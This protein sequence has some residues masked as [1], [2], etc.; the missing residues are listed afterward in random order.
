MIFMFRS[1]N[2]RR[3]KVDTSFFKHFKKRSMVLLGELFF[4]DVD[5]TVVLVCI[6]STVT[7]FQKPQNGTQGEVKVVR[8]RFWIRP[9]ITMIQ[10]KICQRLELTFEGGGR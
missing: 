10:E 3:I 5:F 7:K 8:S 2:T 6:N 9:Q 1:C 4:N